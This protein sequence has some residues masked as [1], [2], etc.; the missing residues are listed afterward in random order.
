M[1]QIINEK[2]PISEANPI[3]ARHY[4]YE[5]FT[6][7][8]HFHS[9]YEIIYMKEGF[10]RCFVGDC[11]EEFHAGDLILFGT[12]LPHYMRSDDVFC[13]GQ[14][15]LRTRGTIIQFEQNFMEYSIEH[16][17]QFHQIRT[18][19][20]EAERG[21]RF[22]RQDDA[23]LAEAAYG[24]PVLKGFNQ[25]A[26]LLDLLQ[27]MANTPS[28]KVL[29]SPHY[30]E[31]FPAMGD[32]RIDKIISFIN[33]NYTR[34]IR[35]DE[36]AEKANMNPTAFCRYFKENTGKTLLQYVMDMRVGYACKLLAVGNMDISQ[37]ALECGFDSITHFNRTFKQWTQLTPTQYRN[38]VLKW[39]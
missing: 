8:W 5:C 9:Q 24:F 21:I 14:P 12:N 39:L 10:G 18:L 1:R 34:K 28:R 13:N 16:Y 4:D 17:P 7:P 6:Y 15:E 25:I 3:K 38:N 30:S 36:I 35:L 2:L 11:I 37:I 20:E 26:Q 22:P 32:K 23:K 33:S 31:K 27:E 29:A 19:L